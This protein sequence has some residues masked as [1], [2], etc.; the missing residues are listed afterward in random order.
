M[1]P[2]WTFPVH[3]A[4]LL[5]AVGLQSHSLAQTPVAP[6]T[7]EMKVQALRSTALGTELWLERASDGAQI[8]VALPPAVRSQVTLTPGT[9]VE[10]KVIGAGV[11]YSV[12]GELLTFVPNESGKYLLSGPIAAQT[13]PGQHS[14]KIAA[15]ERSLRLADLTQRALKASGAKVVVLAWTR[16]DMRR[17][18]LRYSDLA[19]A[20]QQAQ[21]DGSQAWRVLA[22]QQICGNAQSRLVTSGLAD[23]FL[24][25]PA[26]L[27]AAWV[28]PEAALQDRLEALLQEGT[29]AE[30][31]RSGR[32]ST[33]SH[34]WSTQYQATSQW[35]LETLAMAQDDRVTTRQLAQ[36]WL[37]AQGYQPTTIRLKGRRPGGVRLSSLNPAFDDHPNGQPFADRLVL[38]SADSVLRWLR[39]RQLGSAPVRLALP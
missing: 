20:F 21:D 27:E 31:M 23:L 39:S 30:T 29:A 11:L 6:A 32:F 25:Q 36:D 15:V 2:V 8:P 16:H 10:A 38:V 7:G 33:A 18:G 24:Q 34:A 4:G 1:P 37:Q 12:S 3:L 17:Y 35:V 19:L 14:G 22:L 26:R 5:C 28:I 13:C 9:R